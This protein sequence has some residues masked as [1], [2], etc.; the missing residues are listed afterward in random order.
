MSDLRTSTDIALSGLKAQTERLRVISQN[1]ANADSVATEAGGKP[2]QRKTIT[3]K[4][5]LDR[6]LGAEVV[7]VDKVG[8]DSAEFGKRYDPNHPGAGDDGYV[9]LPN[10]NPLI[11]I[12]DMKEAQRTYEANLNVIKTSRDLMSRTLE[13][14]K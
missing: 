1:L 2:Y 3:F 14:I 9:L 4:N 10:V 6:E 7:T 5:E 12:M 13:L 8:V 11:E